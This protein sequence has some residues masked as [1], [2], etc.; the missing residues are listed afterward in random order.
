M[1]AHP[2]RLCHWISVLI[3]SQDH[4]HV[5]IHCYILL[6]STFHEWTMQRYTM[7]SDSSWLCRKLHHPPSVSPR[8]N[9]PWIP[10]LA[11]QYDEGGCACLRG[12]WSQVIRRSLY[13]TH[14]L[15]GIT[16][17]VTVWFMCT[18]IE[19]IT[20]Y[21]FIHWAIC[22]WVYIFIHMKRCTYK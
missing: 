9:R 22:P 11:Q 13:R 18:T 21:L 4:S 1:T 12:T 3:G 5:W 6:C 19:N 2:L 10:H 17:K 14:I 16:V 20:V 7:Y 15:K 8:N